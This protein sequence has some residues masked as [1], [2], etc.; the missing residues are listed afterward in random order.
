ML[1]FQKKAW[2]CTMAASKKVKQIQQVTSRV[3]KSE[4]DP[5][6]Y[7]SKKPSWYF[8]QCDT[9]SW[10]LDENNAGNLFWSEVL[11]FLK[12]LEKRTWHEILSRSNNNNHFIMAS[13]L[14]TVAK[15]RL[16][17][18]YIEYD[19][20]VSLRLN[21]T[22]RLYGFIVDAVFHVLWFDKVH[23]DNDECV[24]RSH[25]KHT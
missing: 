5:A 9:V 19:A 20:V 25:M 21:G 18:M 8:S 13:D 4:Y 22:H 23:G 10:A 14:N 15:K 6:S 16:E 1:L 12:S 24:C 2:L 17:E 7:Y 3:A 11:P